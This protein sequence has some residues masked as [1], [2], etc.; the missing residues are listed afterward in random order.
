[1]D[2]DSALALVLVNI[3][4]IDSHYGKLCVC[5]KCMVTPA[6]RRLHICC[7]PTDHSKPP[8]CGVKIK[9]QFEGWQEDPECTSPHLKR[10]AIP[11]SA[12][13][14]VLGRTRVADVNM[15]RSKVGRC[16][17]A[18]GG[19]ETPRKTMLGKQPLKK[20]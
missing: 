6:R 16:D 3:A 17:L 13:D 7:R 20:G 1:M 15:K 2:Q 19:S 4:I 18:A 14:G 5:I 10:G 12:E 8:Y 9:R 11:M